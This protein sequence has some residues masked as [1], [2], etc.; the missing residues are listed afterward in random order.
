MSAT[1]TPNGHHYLKPFVIPDELLKIGR[2]PN[3]KNL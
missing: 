3:Y 2:I 1:V